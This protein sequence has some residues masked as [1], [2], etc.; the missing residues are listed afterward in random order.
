MKIP[1]ILNKITEGKIKTYKHNPIMGVY[2]LMQE[3]NLIYIGQSISIASRIEAHR[4]CTN[5]YIFD[6][7][8]FIECKRE[9]LLKIEKKYTDLL[10]PKWN[11]GTI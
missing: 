6:S 1:K 11:T 10:R 4:R 3:E 5:N 8:Y 2:F 7:V 9:D